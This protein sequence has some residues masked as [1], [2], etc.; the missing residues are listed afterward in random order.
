MN[1]DKCRRVFVETPIISTSISTIRDE[2][3]P[4]QDK[5]KQLTE[6]EKRTNDKVQNLDFNIKT[7]SKAQKRTDGK[8][9]DMRLLYTSKMNIMKTKQEFQSKLIYKGLF[10]LIILESID[11]ILEV[12]GIII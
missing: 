6:S 9:H 8:V 10:A 2:V 5:I 11:I 12:I 7:V 1:E 4:I 3:A